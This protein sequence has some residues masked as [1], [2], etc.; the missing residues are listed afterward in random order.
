MEKAEK[1]KEFL[2]LSSV[3]EQLIKDFRL[4]QPKQKDLISDYT[5]YLT[6]DRKDNEAEEKEAT[7]YFN[8]IN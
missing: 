7:N 8:L 4:L 1:V 5:H 6:T 2:E 3:E